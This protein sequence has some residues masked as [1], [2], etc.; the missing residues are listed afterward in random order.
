MTFLLLITL[1]LFYAAIWI[2]FGVQLVAQATVPVKIVTAVA[3]TDVVLA[4]AM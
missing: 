2:G 3:V 1:P 4:V